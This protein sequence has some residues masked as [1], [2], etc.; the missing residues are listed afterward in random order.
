MLL[1]LFQAKMHIPLGRENKS[2]KVKLIFLEYTYK[3]QKQNLKKMKLRKFKK[4][5]E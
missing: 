1:Y 3:N 4:K 2:T 5:Y